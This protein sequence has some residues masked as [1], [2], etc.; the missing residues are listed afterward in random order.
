MDDNAA[1]AQMS[2]PR[3]E[4]VKSKEEGKSIKEMLCLED[5]DFSQSFL[6]P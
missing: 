3:V 6:S 4:E 2:A 5:K 1:A